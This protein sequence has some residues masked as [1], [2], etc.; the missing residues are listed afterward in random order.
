MWK[1]FLLL[2]LCILQLSHIEAQWSREYCENIYN[3]CQRFTPRIG[4]FD[5]TIDS[6]NRHCR[7]ER[8]GRWNSVSRCEMEKATCL[9]IFRRCD[10][11]SCNNIA[12]VLEL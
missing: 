12:D 7:R 11:M 9:L 3:D 2:V 6:F 10:D 1:I 5:E 4:R 8:R